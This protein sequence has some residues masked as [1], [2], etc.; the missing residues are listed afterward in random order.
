MACDSSVLV[1]YRMVVSVPGQTRQR[2]IFLCRA[3]VV[4]VSALRDWLLKDPL[5]RS[6]L[7][8]A[9]PA[10]T[11]LQDLVFFSYGLFCSSIGGMP[12][13]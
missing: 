7:F 5:C 6:P 2:Y 3:V 13:S 8:Y 1:V 12:Q 11:S 9:A 10:S 4:A